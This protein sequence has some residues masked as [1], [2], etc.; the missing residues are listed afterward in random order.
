[1]CQGR[2]FFLGF[3]AVLQDQHDRDYE[4]QQQ[5]N[6]QHDPRNLMTGTWSRD[7]MVGGDA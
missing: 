3:G 2:R 5:Q 7:L 1:V 6:P 4:G